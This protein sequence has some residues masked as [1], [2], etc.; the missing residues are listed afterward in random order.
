M[1]TRRQAAGLEPLVKK[2]KIIN[3]KKILG[4]V[5]LEVILLEGVSDYIH[6]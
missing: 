2:T 6:R 3:N 4:K 1:I 5:W